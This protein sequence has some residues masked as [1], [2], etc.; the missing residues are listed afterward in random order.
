MSLTEHR[1]VLQRNPLLHSHVLLHLDGRI[2]R[3]V[4]VDSE[5]EPLCEIERMMSCSSSLQR[6]RSLWTSKGRFM[7]FFMTEQCVY[8]QEKVNT[9]KAEAVRC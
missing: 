3:G 4:D 5:A 1:R 7:P 8:V 6:M 9:V 2:N